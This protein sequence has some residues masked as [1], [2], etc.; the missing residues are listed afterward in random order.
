MNAYEAILNRRSIRSFGNKPV[1]IKNLRRMVNAARLAPSAGNMQ[2]LEFI[3]VTSASLREKIFKHLQWAGYL[4]PRLNPGQKDKP[5]AYIIILV[6]LSK[7]ALPGA[8][9]LAPDLRDIGAAAENIMLTAQADNIAS[10]WLGAI[11]K[12][13]L[14]RLFKL[15]GGINLDS[16][17]ALGQANMPSKPV[18][19]NGCVKYFLDNN[20]VLNVPK[21]SLNSITHLN[22]FKAKT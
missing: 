4:S 13:K 9:N 17:I 7:L 5:K 10:C 12:E 14:R 6:N 1:G 15:P 21:R 22:G 2:I 16:V 11:D 3:I 18:R 19:F 8:K 20:N